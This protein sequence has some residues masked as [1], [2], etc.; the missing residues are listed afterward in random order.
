MSMREHPHDYY[1]R[2]HREDEER[3]HTRH[4]YHSEMQSRDC[5]H[6]ME[7]SGTLGVVGGRCRKCSYSTI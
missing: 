5:D 3:E 1:D 6:D 2:A 7:Y 4:R